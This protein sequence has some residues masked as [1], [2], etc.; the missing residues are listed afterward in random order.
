[1]TEDVLA[2]IPARKGSKG[3]KDKN[4]RIFNGKPLIAWTI[5]QANQSGFVSK[6]IVS[7]D[8]AEI[9]KIATNY[10]AEVPFLRPA[11][12]ATDEAKSIDLVLHALDS[13]DIFKWVVLLQ[14][15]SPLRKSDDI[16]KV[17]T[18]C[19]EKEK[20]S[21]VSVVELSEHPNSA[22]YLNAEGNLSPFV[23]DR[24]PDARRQDFSKLYKLNGAVY[25]Y[26]SNY[27]REKKSFVD[28]NTIGICMPKERSVDIDDLFDWKIAELF[29]ELQDS[30]V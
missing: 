20:N 18:T 11:H 16:D 12:M 10:G 1:M 26:N 14:P 6:T 28:S 24:N 15:T 9:A 7:T 23:I 30:G 5:E 19:W 17:I 27:L 21:A 29:F 8:C 25:F 4:I 2:I 13:V 3:I 22:F